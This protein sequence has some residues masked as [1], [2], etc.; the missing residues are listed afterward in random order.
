MCQTMSPR[1]GHSRKCSAC[2][3]CSSSLLLNPRQRPS[4]QVCC[5]HLACI[6]RQLL[7]PGPMP[8][9]KNP[10]IL[11]VQVMARPA[12]LS[13]HNICR[14]ICCACTSIKVEQGRQPSRL[15]WQPERRPKA[16]FTLHPIDPTPCCCQPPLHME[17]HAQ[18]LLLPV[19]QGTCCSAAGTLD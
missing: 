7:V 9:C 4:P 14:R 8:R 10:A 17:T 12:P 16:A 15:R 1:P 13:S 18:A 11:L 2:S 19:N 3:A 6:A 5:A